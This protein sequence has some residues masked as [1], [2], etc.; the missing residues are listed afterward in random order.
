MRAPGG[1][2]EWEYCPEGWRTLDPRI[3]GWNVEAVVEAQKR[4]WPEFVRLVESRGPLGINHT[5]LVP[6]ARSHIAH[7]LVLS[8]GYVLARAAHG[9]DTVSF[10]DWGGGIGHYAVFARALL[11]D[12]RVEYF[13]KDVPLLCAGGR[14]VLPDA[15]FFER[16]EDARGR[17]YDLAMASGSLHYSQDWRATLGLLAGVTERYVY[18]TRLPVVREAASFV[19]VQRPYGCGYDTEYL[20]W[21]LNRDE[22]LAGAR[23]A[24]LELEREFLIDERPKVHH[25]PE[26]A[27]YGGFL[28]RGR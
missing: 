2:P 15:T 1:P 6:S 28:F 21:F 18:V 19:V 16:E 9:K 3:K 5:D 20:G 22:F 8:F 10:L 17:S 7:N 12:A 24:G 23:Q 25:A 11:P 26:Q 4:T 13:C 27:E 14:E